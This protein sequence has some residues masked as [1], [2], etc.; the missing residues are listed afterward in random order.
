MSQ[1]KRSDKNSITAA[2]GGFKGAM[3]E[4]PIPEGIE[5]RSD[6]ELVIWQ[7]FTRA[8]A[9]EDW[10]D[11]DLILLSKV[12]RME[13]DIRS[14]QET[15]DRSGVLIQNKRGTLVANPLITIIDT[16]ERRQLAVIRSMSLNQMASDPRTINSTARTQIDAKA[17]MSSFESDD[18]IAMPRAN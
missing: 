1:K 8:R 17:K 6:K 9:R 11:L 13:A 4:V 5:L 16:L 15:L 12:V 18:L 14:H 7:Q 10:R 2:L 3:Q